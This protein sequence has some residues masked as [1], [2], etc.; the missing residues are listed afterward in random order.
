MKQIDGIMMFRI[1]SAATIVALA[2]TTPTFAADMAV[3][4][5]RAIPAAPVPFSW[6]GCYLGGH[7]GGVVSDDRT[8]GALGNSIGFSSAGV[9]GGGQIGC[10][11]QFASG[12]VAGL[13]GRAAWST[14]TNTHR[15]S[16]RNLITGVTVPSQ[17]TLSND[18][19]AS[20]TARIGYSFADRWLVFV[21]GGAAWTREKID[22]AFTN[23]R[24]I[25][26]DPSATMNRTGWTVGTGVDWAFASHWSA[27]LEYNYYDFG[28]HGRTLN[29]AA[30]NANV[31]LNSLKDSV[32]ALTAGLN[33]H[34]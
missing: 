32:H 9:T 14:L 31:N 8:T 21:R 33:Y 22:D 16:V 17:F 19:L 11:Y 15:A 6:T 26:V 1:I 24:G 13:E 12:W 7:I 23:P 3:K 28:T 34:F 27:D 2:A 4:A 20:A 18:F 25:A 5:P 30:N 29:D 10:D